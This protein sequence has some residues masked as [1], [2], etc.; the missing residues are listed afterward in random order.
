[1][2]NLGK[3]WASAPAI[4]HRIDIVGVA[5]SIFATPTIKSPVFPVG[6]RSF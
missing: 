4:S 2:S 5:S 3:Y 6:W 1:M